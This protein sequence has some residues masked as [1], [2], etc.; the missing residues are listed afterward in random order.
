MGVEPGDRVA[1]WLPNVPETCAVML[2]AASIGATFSSTSPDFGASGVIDRFGQIR[3]VVDRVLPLSRA[4]E[5]HRVLEERAV[6]GKVILVP[7]E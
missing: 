2:A 6:F 4:V 1:A 7:G 3:P 5:G